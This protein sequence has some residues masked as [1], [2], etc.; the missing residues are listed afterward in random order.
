MSCPSFSTPVHSFRPYQSLDAHKLRP[1][2][3][4]FSD[5]SRR[6]QHDAARRLTPAGHR[7]QQQAG[8][9]SSLPSTSPLSLC[10]TNSTSSL[11]SFAVDA[12]Q[13]DD[14]GMEDA[15][16]S[17]RQASLYFTQ[18]IGSGPSSSLIMHQQQQ[19][20]QPAFSLHSRHQQQPHPSQ[21]QP[22]PYGAQYPPSASSSSYAYSAM[23][24]SP[25]TAPAGWKDSIS[26]HAASLPPRHSQPM[27]GSHGAPLPLFASPASA[28]VVAAAAV[29]AGDMASG[30]SG[31]AAVGR[32]RKKKARSL[33]RCLDR[34]KHSKAEQRR[35]GEMKSLFDQLQDISGCVYKDRIHILTLAIQTIQGQQETIKQ[36]QHTDG[37]VSVKKEQKVKK[38]RDD[39]NPASPASPASSPSPS[40]SSSSPVVAASR[41]V[42]AGRQSPH[43]AVDAA[44][45]VVVKR[46]EEEPLPLS[47][48]QRRTPPL[49]R[50][51]EL[52]DLSSDIAVMPPVSMESTLSSMSASAASESGVYGSLISA[53]SSSSALATFAVTGG[54]GSEGLSRGI[55]KLMEHPY[56][57][58]E[59]SLNFHSQQQPD[60]GHNH[61]LP[62]THPHSLTQP[63]LHS[64]G[65]AQAASSSSSSFSSIA[66][67]SI[68]GLP[69]SSSP[70]TAPSSAYPI[71]CISPGPFVLSFTPQPDW[72]QPSTAAEFNS[73]KQ[74]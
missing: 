15:M 8:D 54:S 50:P 53:A 31:G 51:V 34:E 30:G 44:E 69:S 58:E 13:L 2:F 29:A 22:D 66:R 16:L 59:Q 49:H 61:A 36:L 74:H 47:K 55:S 63:P 25:L 48:K 10:S 23:P 67:S 64:N 37:D 40:S 28:P 65:A 3:V 14:C 62:P 72:W 9:E 17:S 60:D 7:Q 20:Q 33:R 42:D 70:A 5:A 57:L 18:Q 11:S 4:P 39:S 24:P 46:E 12:G 68:S 6:Q 43:A 21:L 71:P 35:R 73:R 52:V 45:A 32:L 1:S 19:Q 27:D 26:A 41:Q 56:Y 38:Q